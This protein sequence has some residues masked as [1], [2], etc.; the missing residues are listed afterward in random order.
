[1]GEENEEDPRI[2]SICDQ[3]LKAKPSTHQRI[4]ESLI[5]L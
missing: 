2:P 4:N 5:Q 3:I 1:M